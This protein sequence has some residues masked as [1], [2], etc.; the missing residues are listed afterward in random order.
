MEREVCFFCFIIYVHNLL[1]TDKYMAGSENFLQAIGTKL[2]LHSTFKTLRPSR[3][4]P[5]TTIVNHGIV[6]H[7]TLTGFVSSVTLCVFVR[8]CV[9]VCLC[10]CMSV[11]VFM[12]VCVSVS[13]SVCL[14][15][16]DLRYIS[17]WQYINNILYVL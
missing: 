3:M 15:V 12:C 1:N 17:I 9:C 14:C 6:N 10:L 2:E 11:C 16:R 5:N 7:S 8:V 13:V 4:L